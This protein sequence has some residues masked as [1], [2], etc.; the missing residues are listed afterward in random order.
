MSSSTLVL[1]HRASSSHRPWTEFRLLFNGECEKLERRSGECPPCHQKYSKS[2]KYLNNISS[3]P[4]R[5]YVKILHSQKP[6]DRIDPWHT[7]T[8][9]RGILRWQVPPRSGPLPAK[10]ASKTVHFAAFITVVVGGAVSLPV[11]FACRMTGCSLAIRHVLTA[12]ARSRRSRITLVS[13]RS[14]MDRAERDRLPGGEGF[15]RQYPRYKFVFAPLKCRKV[16]HHA[17]SALFCARR[18]GR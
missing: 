4:S 3:K 8:R 12:F 11:E 2:L 6:V 14:L 1:K 5:A 13:K 10:S 17:R 18:S 7:E 16:T 9:F 15:E